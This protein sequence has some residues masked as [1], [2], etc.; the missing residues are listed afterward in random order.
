[1]VI[2]LLLTETRE[3]RPELETRESEKEPRQYLIFYPFALLPVPNLTVEPLSFSEAPATSQEKEFIRDAR[4]VESFEE[5]EKVE[6]K[7]REQTE[8]KRSDSR[9]DT[10]ITLK[11][12]ERR[13]AELDKVVEKALSE[14]DAA[15]T[16]EEKAEEAQDPAAQKKKWWGWF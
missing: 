12:E 14:E 16:K 11:E 5:A 13:R 1:M 8:L 2:Q 7:L 15:E 9:D 3:C 10:E 6:K 4:V